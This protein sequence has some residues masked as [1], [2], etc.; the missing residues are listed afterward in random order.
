MH[1]GH[2]FRTMV[3]DGP[4]AR[5]EQIGDELVGFAFN[6]NSEYFALTRRQA[7]EPLLDV[8]PAQFVVP[9]SE[10]ELGRIKLA[11]V[12]RVLLGVAHRRVGVL[13]ESVDV[14]GS[15]W[16]KTDADRGGDANFA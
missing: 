1:F 13:K 4:G 7:G 16:I 9:R 10:I 12:R 14:V 6:E 11:G 8:G 15:D 2:D 5:A 3:L